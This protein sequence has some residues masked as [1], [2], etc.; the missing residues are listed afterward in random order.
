MK[1]C[2]CRERCVGNMFYPPYTAALLYE[3]TALSNG[4]LI[5]NELVP[6]TLKNNVP[7]LK[8]H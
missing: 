2:M 6:S 4:Q 3:L 1:V 7:Q 5:N 8:V